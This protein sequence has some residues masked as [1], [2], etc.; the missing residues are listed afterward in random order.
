MIYVDDFIHR[1]EKMISTDQISAIIKINSKFEYKNIPF[2]NNIPQG[3]SDLYCKL[4][5]LQI[6]YPRQFELLPI[7]QFRLIN[8]KYLYFATINHI[9]K[10]GFNIF[11]NKCGRRMGYSKYQ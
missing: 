3:I 1:I 6:I 2:A 7:E 4:N 11:T 9:E 8:D 5:S 10:L